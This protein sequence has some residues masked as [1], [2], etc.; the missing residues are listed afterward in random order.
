MA[1]EAGGVVL[2][3]LHSTIDQT[4]KMTLDVVVVTVSVMVAVVVAV[5]FVAEIAL[6]GVVQTPNRNV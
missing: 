2:F 5:A 1:I 4:T 6:D 3:F